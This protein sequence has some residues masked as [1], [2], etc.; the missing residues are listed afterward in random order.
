MELEYTIPLAKLNARK[1]VNH[2]SINTTGQWFVAVKAAENGKDGISVET[3]DL[4]NGS[5]LR[6]S[7]QLVAITENCR[8]V[9]VQE[10]NVKQAGARVMADH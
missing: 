10:V 1:E 9:A 4:R 6:I 3:F 7:K 2:V 5:T 8:V